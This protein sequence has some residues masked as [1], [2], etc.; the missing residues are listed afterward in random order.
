MKW[1]LLSIS[2]LSIFP[3]M[4]FAQRGC[5]EGYYEQNAPGLN[6]CIPIPVAEQSPPPG[7]K[8]LKTWGAI[9]AEAGGGNIGVSVNKLSK[10]KAKKEAMD[11]C[12]ETGAKTCRVVLAYNHQCAAIASVDGAKEGERFTRTYGSGPY[13]ESTGQDAVERCNSANP[14]RNCKVIYSDCTKP[15]LQK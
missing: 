15:I 13:V 5:P 7:P 8:W 14:G 3:T 6:S 9:A 1:T 2:L 12:E 11:L 4:A 10:S